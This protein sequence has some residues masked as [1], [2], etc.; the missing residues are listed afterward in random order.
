MIMNMINFEEFSD[1]EFIFRYDYEQKK[2]MEFF[3]QY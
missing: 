1:E 2:R 3:Q